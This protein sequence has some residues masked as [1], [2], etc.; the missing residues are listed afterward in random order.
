MSQRALKKSL[1]IKLVG[2]G[3]WSNEQI[4]GIADI[5]VSW[6]R[7]ISR[8]GEGPRM[9]P[10]TTFLKADFS[11]LDHFLGVIGKY[12]PYESTLS[13]PVLVESLRFEDLIDVCRE[14]FPDYQML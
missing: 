7:F 2:C 5:G 12:L 9:L 11:S 1:E 8:K 10:G 4:S 6:V 14:Y 3:G 13:A